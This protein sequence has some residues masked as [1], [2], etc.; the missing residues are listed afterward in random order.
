MMCKSNF[1]CCDES[2]LHVCLVRFH[3]SET[4]DTPSN[5]A[6]MPEADTS[7]WTKPSWIAERLFA[8]ASGT[9][10]IENGSL[11]AIQTR[12]GVTAIK[13]LKIQVNEL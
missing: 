5:R 8:W 4:I 2:R 12:E 13:P 10:P 6:A 7:T 9:E 1:D 3:C 11:L